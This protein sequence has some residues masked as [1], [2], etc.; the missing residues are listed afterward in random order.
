MYL[1]SKWTTTVLAFLALLRHTV[2]VLL[3]F[4]LL[5]VSLMQSLH[6]SWGDVAVGERRPRDRYLEVYVPKDFH[7]ARDSLRDSQY[8]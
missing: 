3:E 4:F 5:R 2:V 6:G 1:R 7:M 8:V